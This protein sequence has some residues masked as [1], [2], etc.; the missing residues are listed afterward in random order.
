MVAGGKVR[1]RP[2]LSTMYQKQKGLAITHKNLS[3]IYVVENRQVNLFMRIGS[4]K[5]RGRK[6]KGYFAMLLKTNVENMS[7]SCLSTMLLKTS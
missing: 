1:K 4:G 3:E 2:P 6:M 7:V 5:K